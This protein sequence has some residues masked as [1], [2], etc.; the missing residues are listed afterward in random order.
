MLCVPVWNSWR[1]A[2]WEVLAYTRSSACTGSRMVFDD[3]ATISDDPKGALVGSYGKDQQSN[4]GRCKDGGDT[5][6]R[7]MSTDCIKRFQRV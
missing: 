5:T 2:D 6:L 4:Q 1:Y 3:F 7:V